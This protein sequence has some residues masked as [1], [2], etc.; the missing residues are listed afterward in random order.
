[1]KKILCKISAVLVLI[2][3]LSLPENVWPQQPG[4]T[5]PVQVREQSGGTG[6][7]VQDTNA[8]QDN[9]PS[10]T[11]KPAVEGSRLGGESDKQGAEFWPPIW[12]HRLK[13]TDTLLVGVTFLLFLA[14]LALWLATQDLV[15]DAKHTAERQLRAYISMNPEIIRGFGHTE[16]IV[17]DFLT[18][19]HGSTPA[20]EID[21]AF[22]MGV[23]P[24]PL[25]KGFT[26]PAADRFVTDKSALFPAAN[27]ISWFNNDRVLDPDDVKNVE[28][29]THRFYVWGTTTYRD[30]FGKLRHTDFSASVGGRTFA[31]SV[32][33][34]QAGMKDPGFRWQFGTKHNHAS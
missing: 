33:A 30:A 16:K 3:I 7:H 6:M 21:Y 18:K 34:T 27:M 12:G 4:R 5:S 22:G 2:G 32:K 10:T 15:K 26:F 23:F 20:F 31:E 9:P 19:N 17:V 28:K 14:T 25:P 24:N 1:M 11:P 13:I 29:D 8:Q